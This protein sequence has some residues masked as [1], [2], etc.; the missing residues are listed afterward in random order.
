MRATPDLTAPEA[1]FPRAARGDSRLGDRT[2]PQSMAHRKRRCP[3]FVHGDDPRTI[4][5]RWTTPVDNLGHW[6]PSALAP[7]RFRLPDR[8]GLTA[9]RKNKRRSARASSV[10][11]NLSNS[12]SDP[13]RNLAQ[14]WYELWQDYLTCRFLQ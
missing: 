11:S 4:K 5:A 12:H 1:E 14:L 3:R 10:P 6:P 9:S 2:A 13:H 7:P 8:A